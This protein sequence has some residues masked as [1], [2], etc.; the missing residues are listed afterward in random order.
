MSLLGKQL[1]MNER[2]QKIKKIKDSEKKR[3]NERIKKEG[4]GY[5]SGIFI[6]I[7]GTS[8]FTS[9]TLLIRKL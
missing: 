1:E 6:V 9:N 8:G 7:K 4:I 2:D 5:T 3:K